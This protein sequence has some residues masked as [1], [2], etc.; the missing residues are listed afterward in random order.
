MR[1][2][3]IFPRFTGPYGAERLILKM[4]SELTHLNHNIT[5]Y[6]HKFHLSCKDIVSS[7][8]KIVETGFPPIKDHDIASFLDLILMPNLALKINGNYDIF[9]LV[10]W[11]SAF[12]GFLAKIL[13]SKYRKIPFI[14]HC[15]EPPRIVYDLKD[16]T[17][18][19]YP[20]SKKILLKFILPIL[21]YVDKY[22][23]RRLDKIISIS[24]WTAKQVR[25]I[26]SRDSEIVYPGVEIE[27]FK[28]YS[29]EVARKKLRLDRDTKLFISVSKLHRRKRIDKALRIYEEFSKSFRK[30][31]FLIIGDGPEK[32]N[33]KNLVK[34]MNLKN[35]EFLGRISDDEIPVYYAAADYFIFTAKNEPFGIAPLEAKVAGCELLGVNTHYPIL[36]WE[37]S[38][39]KVIEIYE[40]IIK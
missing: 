10:N 22:S 24:D 16:I 20:F 36:S 12:G 39:K 13:H 21:K 15:T 34:K 29:K 17:L 8:V 40:R 9:H 26:Y 35:V 25:E 19:K 4:S 7:K 23:V 28:R 1:I 6:T 14:Y 27:R 3:F 30:S 5:I 33:L 18:S 38:T 31:K 32:Q 2:C 37:D 11:Q